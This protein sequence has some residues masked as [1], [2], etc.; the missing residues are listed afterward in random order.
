ML[1]IT[2]QEAEDIFA[3]LGYGFH[4]NNEQFRKLQGTIQLVDVREPE[5][6]NSGHIPGAV[7]MPL[8]ELAKGTPIDL[9]TNHTIVLY[10]AGGIRSQTAAL[11][12]WQQGFRSLYHLQKGIIGW[13]GD[14]EKS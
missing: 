7:H 11:A 14:V 3:E 5:E 9:D 8:S 4:L 12:F 13:D 10:C 6:W 1:P 2:E